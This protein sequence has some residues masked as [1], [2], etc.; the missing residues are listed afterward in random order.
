[1]IPGNMIPPT[2]SSHTIPGNKIHTG[3]NLFFN[4]LKFSTATWASLT[5]KPTQQPVKIP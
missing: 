2:P 4:G 3:G 5:V 1:M